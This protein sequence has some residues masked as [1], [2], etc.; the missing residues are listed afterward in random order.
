[1]DQVIIHEP[2]VGCHPICTTCKA[3]VVLRD[4]WAVWNKLRGRWELQATFDTYHCNYCDRETEIAWEVDEGF[5]K[6]RICR[7]NDAFRR[8]DVMHGTLVI[9]QGI[10][11]LGEDAT[12]AIVLKVAEHED[13]TEDNDPRGERDFGALEHAGEKIFWKIDYYDRD[14]KWHS[15]DAANPEVTCRVLTI[16]LASEY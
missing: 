10:Q 4:A 14:L 2:L 1:M 13:F 3:K 7:L 11:A 12:R 16:M 8:A 6:L 9:T 5:R 15:P